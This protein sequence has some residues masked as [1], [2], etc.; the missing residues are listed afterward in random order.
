L[1]SKKFSRVL[2]AALF[3]W[4]MYPLHVRG[5]IPPETDERDMDALRDLVESQVA[6]NREWALDLVEQIVKA[7]VP[8][9]RFAERY[10]HFLA[11]RAQG[12]PKRYSLPPPHSLRRIRIAIASNLAG[13]A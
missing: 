5:T 6:G 3:R 13:V 4:E 10:V 2:Q 9:R 11:W 7:P 12:S 8:G 1:A